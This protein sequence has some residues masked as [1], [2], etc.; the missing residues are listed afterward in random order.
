MALSRVQ[1]GLDDLFVARTA[2]EIAGEPVLDLCPAQVRASLEEG[3]RRDQV[4]RN[5]EAALGGSVVEERLLER[6][7]DASERE[8]LHR[9][10][11]GAVGLE[12]QDEAGVD[13]PP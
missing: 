13:A 1:D 2:A 3:V 8:L 7:E 4:A 5:A 9:D 10:H 11:L 6:I 12:G